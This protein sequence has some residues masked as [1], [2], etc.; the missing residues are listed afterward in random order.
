MVDVAGGGH[1]GVQLESTT[2]TY[3]A[4]AVFVPIESESLSENRTDAVRSPILGRAVNSG[5]VKGRAM[6]QGE[7]TM[8]A[9][10][11]IMVYFLTASR[12]GNNIAKTGAGPY[13][14]T[15]NDDAVAHLKTNNRSLTI[16]TSRAGIGFAYLGCQVVGSRF[17]FEDGIPKVA[18]TII[19]REQTEAYT[20]GS[21]TDPT[22]VPFAADEIDI[23]IAGSSRVDL[24]SFEMVVDDSGEAK[25]NLSGAAGADYIKFG[26]H[27]AS[28]S[29]EIDFES[30]ADY[31]IWVARTVQEVIMTWT[32]GA[33]QI[34]S[35]ELHGGLYDSFEVGLDGLGDQVKAAAQINAAY[36]GG[37]DVA[38]TEIVLTTNANLAQVT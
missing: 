34:V 11:E 37:G 32:K 35:I 25:F 13:V 23:K 18:W 31:A 36:V 15:M 1:V 12:M 3:I 22:E 17:F 33:N 28:A 7:I 9:I 19:G 24:D 16:V 26:E 20:P 10:P 38:A 6:V 4:P 27:T 5:K 14:Y 29:F 2:G 30:K 8:E 21:V